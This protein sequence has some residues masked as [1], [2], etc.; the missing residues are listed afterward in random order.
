[1]SMIS[2]SIEKRLVT[3]LFSYDRSSKLGASLILHLSGRS[4]AAPHVMMIVRDSD[5]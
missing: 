2:D 4:K 3:K 5:R 1:M